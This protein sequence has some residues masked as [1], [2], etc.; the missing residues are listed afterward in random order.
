MCHSNSPLHCRGVY[1]VFAVGESVA[2]VR[3]LR[4]VLLGKHKSRPTWDKFLVVV[5]LE[6]IHVTGWFWNI[7][8]HSASRLGGIHI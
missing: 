2:L 1:I 5:T 8:Y 4:V 3:A 7:L 6:S